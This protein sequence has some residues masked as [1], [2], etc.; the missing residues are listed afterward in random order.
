V[1]V[2]ATELRRFATRRAI[3]WLIVLA[4]AVIALGIAIGAANSKIDTTSNAVT[5]CRAPTSAGGAPD[6]GFNSVEECTTQPA[7][8]Q[9]DNRFNLNDDLRDALAGTGVAMLLFGVLFGTTFIGADYIGGALPGQLTFEPR[10][11]YLY[12]LKAIAVAIGT[13][14]VSVFLLLVLTAALVGLAQWRG[15]VGDP[16]G[17]WFVHRLVDIMR[18]TG[19]CALA[20]V[21][22]YAITTVARRSVVAVVG[23]LG[24]AFIV[25]PALTNAIDAFD[26]KTPVFALIAT[27]LNDFTDAPE[28]VT[29]LGGSVLVATIWGAAL[30]FVG[31][32]IFA[33]REIR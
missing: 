11:V 17:D 9:V 18:V 25:E 12:V 19:V 27:A 31:G 32:V 4:L 20:A 28:G 3:R 5:V 13:F 2:L 29:T 8:S 6:T 14:V 30:L 7:N 22:G 26:G 10:R 1:R 33:R 15:V 16:D 21:I 24:F 23:F